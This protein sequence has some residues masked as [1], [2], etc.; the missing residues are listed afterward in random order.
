MSVMAIYDIAVPWTPSFYKNAMQN[1]MISIQYPKINFNLS[2]LTY[3]FP[4]HPSSTPWKHK[5]TL[6]WFFQ[7]VEKRCIGNE[8]V[9]NTENRVIAALRTQSIM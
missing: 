8:W 2:N 6:N 5:K 7:E 1:T 3:S 4:M 9:D